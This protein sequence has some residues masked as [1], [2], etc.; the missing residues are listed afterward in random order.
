MNLKAF[1]VRAQT[2][3]NRL[4][5]LGKGETAHRDC[6]N[7]RDHDRA[8][9]LDRYNVT[10]VEALLRNVP[11]MNRKRIERSDHVIRTDGCVRHRSKTRRLGIKEIVPKLVQAALD[12]LKHGKLREGFLDRIVLACQLSRLLRKPGPLLPFLLGAHIDISRERFLFLLI[13][14][15]PLFYFKTLVTF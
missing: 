1:Q 13:Y 5:R 7:L 12:V 15:V 4:F 3:C 9:P 6:S 14:L 2:V 8:V 11:D 10:A